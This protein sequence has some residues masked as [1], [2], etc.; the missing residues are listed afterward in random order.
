MLDE[1]NQTGASRQNPSDDLKEEIL[2]RLEEWRDR[3]GLDGM[4]LGGAV[5]SAVAQHIHRTD[6]VER[7]IQFSQ[8]LAVNANQTLTHI[9]ETLRRD[10]K[11]NKKLH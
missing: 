9:V 8:F 11:A 2:I 4:E 6:G 7:R 3:Y 10:A 1:D 5:M